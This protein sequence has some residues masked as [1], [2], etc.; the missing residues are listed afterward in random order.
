MDEM[1]LI[2]ALN[3]NLATEDGTMITPESSFYKTTLLNSILLHNSS[4][5]ELLVQAFIGRF[6]QRNGEKLVV[7]LANHKLRR[8]EMYQEVKHTFLE[9]MLVVAL[10]T[11]AY[12]L[13]KK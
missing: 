2:T 9:M 11:L 4:Q 6:L 8:R 12:V 5:A 10:T 7:S 1:Q 3:Q 13:L